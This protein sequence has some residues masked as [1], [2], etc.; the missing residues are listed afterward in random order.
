MELKRMMM[1]RIVNE[2]KVDMHYGSMNSK[3][4]H[5]NR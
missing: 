2:T 3:R 4:I 1:I 5:I